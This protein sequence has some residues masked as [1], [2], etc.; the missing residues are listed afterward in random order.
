[1]DLDS[2]RG[3]SHF[4][5]EGEIPGF[6]GISLPHPQLSPHFF[7]IG[8]NQEFSCW[9]Q[10]FFQPEGICA[11]KDSQILGWNSNS[12]GLGWNSSLA[13]DTKFPFPV[14]FPVFFFFPR[15]NSLV[16]T[17]FFFLILFSRNLGM[18]NPRKKLE[19]FPRFQ[20]C[21]WGAIE[22]FFLAGIAPDFW[23]KGEGKEL[24]NSWR[25]ENPKFPNPW[26]FQRCLGIFNPTWM[27]RNS[28]KINLK[29]PHSHNFSFPNPIF[30]LEQ[31]NFFPPKFL[32]FFLWNS[33]QGWVLFLVFF[34]FV[35]FLKIWIFHV[36]F[37][38]EIQVLKLLEIPGNFWDWGL[39]VFIL[40]FFWGLRKTLRDVGRKRKIPKKFT[41]PKKNPKFSSLNPRL[42]FLWE[43]PEAPNF[44]GS[45]F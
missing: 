5:W 32:N 41:N 34:F 18:L 13:L 28:L 15:L 1:M 2:L 35:P 14:F 31:G 45:L 20:Q 16:L 40:D 12:K 42:E 11:L 9:T 17:L 7:R 44:S 22:L 4:F 23:E 39:G 6:L 26:N 29:F 30:F 36:F 10:I 24:W 25:E 43:L 8:K 33:L 19:V 27:G 38:K 3:N 37:P 21:A